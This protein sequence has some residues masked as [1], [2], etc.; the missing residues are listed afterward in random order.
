MV[1]PTRMVAACV[2]RN[3]IEIAWCCR[4]PHVGNTQW[5]AYKMIER[6]TQR[7]ISSGFNHSPHKPITHIGISPALVTVHN[8]DVVRLR[9]Q[10]AFQWA[11]AHLPFRRLGGSHSARHSPEVPHDVAAVDEE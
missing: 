3:S 11:M 8:E 10:A 5:L 4:K 9:V 7:F 6:R 1:N 2:A